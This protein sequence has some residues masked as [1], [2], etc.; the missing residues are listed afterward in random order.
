MALSGYAPL[1]LNGGFHDIPLDSVINLLGLRRLLLLYPGR[2]GVLGRALGDG[3]REL[4][5][6]GLTGV[7]YD[8]RPVE[9]LDGVDMIAPLWLERPGVLPC[10]RPTDFPPSVGAAVKSIRSQNHRSLMPSA[11]IFPSNLY[12]GASPGGRSAWPRRR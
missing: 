3:L 8:L 9:L 2:P 10:R 4:G 12:L 5:E 6:V 11:T 1:Q 7:V